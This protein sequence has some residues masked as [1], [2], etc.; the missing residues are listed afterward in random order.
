MER[1]G[2]V[3]DV[4]APDEA[5]GIGDVERVTATR[6]QH[7]DGVRRQPVGVVGVDERDESFAQPVPGHCRPPGRVSRVGSF[8]A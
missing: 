4:D 8:G 3:V 1:A 7:T 6:Q 2:V 5:V